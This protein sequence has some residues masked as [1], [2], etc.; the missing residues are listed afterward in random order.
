[1]HAE[2]DLIGLIHHRERLPMLT[3]ED[4]IKVAKAYPG[5]LANLAVTLLP[6]G[7]PP[8]RT[9]GCRKGFR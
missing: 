5:P 4:D 6:R 7:T 9:V 2:G 1:M 8:G 3:L